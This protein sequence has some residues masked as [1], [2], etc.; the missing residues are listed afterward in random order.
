MHHDFR[1]DEAV[2]RSEGRALVAAGSLPC[3]HLWR[4]VDRRAITQRKREEHSL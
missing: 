2:I 1:D 4:I 3:T